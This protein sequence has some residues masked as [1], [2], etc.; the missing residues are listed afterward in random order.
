[1]KNEILFAKEARDTIVKGV[2]ILA[3]AIKV[4]LGPKGRNVVI[5]NEF[6]AP[7]ITN[8]GATIAREI[9]LSNQLDNLGAS[10]IKEVALK[11][12]NLVGDG[13]TTAT[14]L[15][16]SIINFGVRHIDNGINPVIL[17]NKLETILLLI[18]DYLKGNSI[19]VKS[20]SE[21]EKVAF[22]SCGDQEISKLIASTL[23]KIGK[24]GQVNLVES[25][26]FYTK[27]DIIE[28]YDFEEGYASSYMINNEKEL[29]V[30]YKNPYILVTN[31]SIKDSE[32][33][34]NLVNKI[35]EI[36]G[37]LIVISDEIE[38]EIL[39]SLIAEKLENNL[40]FASIRS[41]YHNEKN[42][43]LNDIAV[44]TG[45]TYFAKELNKDL[46]NISLDDLGRA[47]FIK[48]FKNHSTII[49]GM[50]HKEKIQNHCNYLQKLIENSST[51]FESEIYENR[52]KKLLGN[53]ATITI[54]GFTDIEIKERKMK[55]E[56]G[57]YAAK[58]ALKEGICL[59]GGITYLQLKNKL[60][61][62]YKPIA[63]EEKA[64]L[65]IMIESLEAPLKQLLIN[66]GVKDYQS[67][68]NEIEKRQENYGYNVNTSQIEDLTINGI[69]D[70][71]LSVKIA[72]QSSISIASIL[73]TTENI[74]IANDETKKQVANHNMLINDNL[75]GLM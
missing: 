37:S 51:D 47:S 32:E 54:G 16:Q 1:M 10:I 8:D 3:D 34:N 69:Y 28:G 73:L 41:S 12:N 31:Y 33:I 62:N 68:I 43:L 71:S 55:I 56:D 59:G 66:A 14:I 57:I 38:E 52:L 45:A 35:K 6:C 60:I 61:K 44:A 74:V 7:Y 29:S 53:I 64:A 5:S 50:G 72:I 27:V 23:F 20:V 40:K 42:D 75:N 26:N 63:N 21:L 15:A 4:T 46:I 2:N 67:I 18:S 11:T 17:K 25:K 49:Q 30:E 24:E 36:N 58:A 48:I 70:S 22:I 19:A 65:N 39:S 9:N 13:T